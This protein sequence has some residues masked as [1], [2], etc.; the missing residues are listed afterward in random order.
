MLRF[1][2]EVGGGAK[3]HIYMSQHDAILIFKWLN[4]SRAGRTP[5]DDNGKTTTPWITQRRHNNMAGGKTN[6]IFFLKIM[7]IVNHIGKLFMLTHLR[8]AVNSS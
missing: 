7:G 2:A 6:P 3:G 1:L 5:A 4:R 8:A